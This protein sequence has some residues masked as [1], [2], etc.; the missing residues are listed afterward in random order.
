[1][2]IKF[3]CLLKKAYICIYAVR[4]YSSIGR[5]FA[6]QARALSSILSISNMV[7]RLV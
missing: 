2:V 1:M 3:N 4:G 7:A 6:L 5:M